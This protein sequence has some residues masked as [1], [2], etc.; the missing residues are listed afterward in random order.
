MAEILLVEDHPDTNRMLCA[1]LTRAGYMVTPAQ[2][3]AGAIEAARARPFDLLLSDIGL[4]DGTGHE[5]MDALRKIQP[6]PAIATSAFGT[7]ED[8]RR[9]L[10][11]GFSQ[12]MVKPIEIGELFAEVEKMV[13]RPKRE[14][15]T[16]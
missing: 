8:I 15:G 11:H 5:L 7:D 16:N 12:H 1:L 14:S 4:P 6:L 3:V 10:Q 9:S 2:S 13:G